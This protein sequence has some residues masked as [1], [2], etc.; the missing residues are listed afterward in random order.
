[1]KLSDL[2]KLLEK[3]IETE[4][5][6]ELAPW[7][8]LEIFYSKGEDPELLEYGFAAILNIFGTS[9]SSIE[10]TG[11]GIVL[12]GDKTDTAKKVRNL[13]I[14]LKHGPDWDNWDG[15]PQKPITGYGDKTNA[16]F[17]AYRNCAYALLAGKPADLSC[18][19][20]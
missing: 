16:S 15:D 2:E 18:L 8:D 17:T 10:I 20:S 13:L 9:I 12:C 14:G 4:T 7:A 6:Q 5:F 11:D 3:L 1:M 19:A